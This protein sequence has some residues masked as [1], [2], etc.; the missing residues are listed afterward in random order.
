MNEHSTK[1]KGTR[2]VRRSDTIYGK[3]EK[4]QLHL[5]SHKLIRK[6]SFKEDP[7]I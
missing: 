2:Q 6:F 3:R 7:F 4:E 1:A 5:N